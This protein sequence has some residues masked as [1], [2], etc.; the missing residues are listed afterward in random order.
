MIKVTAKYGD[1]YFALTIDYDDINYR[2]DVS[3][4]VYDVL[5]G[6]NG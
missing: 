3:Q 6:A 4:K 1:K 2:V 5:R